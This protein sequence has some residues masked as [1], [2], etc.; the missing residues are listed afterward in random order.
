M[1][2]NTV[3][4]IVD[5]R[6]IVFECARTSLTDVSATE[7][8]E[9]VAEQVE[10]MDCLELAD[11]DVTWERVETPLPTMSRAADFELS[12]VRERYDRFGRYDVKRLS[13]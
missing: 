8:A 11:G 6:E 1:N 10:T 13:A 9:L 3:P 7:I 4:K 5:I 2:G 12:A